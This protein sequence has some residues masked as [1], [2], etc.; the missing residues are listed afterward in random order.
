MI[1]KKNQELYLLHS[2]LADSSFEHI[3]LSESFV[4]N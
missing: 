2:L 1:W 4:S 3:L